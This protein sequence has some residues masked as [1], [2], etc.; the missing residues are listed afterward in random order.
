MKIHSCIIVALASLLA[1]P[2]A[3]SAS[4][5]QTELP[6]ILNEEREDWNVAHPGWRWPNS[7][8][9]NGPNYIGSELWKY[10]VIIVAKHLDLHGKPK[11]YEPVGLHVDRNPMNSWMPE[12]PAN[13]API[14]SRSGINV[15][16]NLGEE[17]PLYYLIYD[18]AK[19]SKRNVLGSARL[20][21]R[22]CKEYRY[23]GSTHEV[24]ERIVELLEK[25]GVKITAFGNDVCVLTEA[26][27]QEE[28][29]PYTDRSRAKQYE[30]EREAWL[31]ENPDATA[32]GLIYQPTDASVDF[33]AKDVRVRHAAAALAK[34]SGKEV[35][36]QPLVEKREFKPAK[37]AT[38]RDTREIQVEQLTRQLEKA[39]VQIVELNPNSLALVTK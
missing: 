5:K 32:Q 36:V 6:L 29:F 39:Y 15:Q 12:I 3:R 18:L 35:F 38:S 7:H 14:R 10:H 11:D 20:E 26:V 8:G 33:P 30:L 16:S 23:R 28:P 25:E 31:L 4:A 9:P 21:K 17:V 24:V 27:G 1:A 37:R 19:N 2:L 22:R 13:M 34:L